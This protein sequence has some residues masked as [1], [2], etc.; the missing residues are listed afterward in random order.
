MQGG[1]NVKQ[2]D[3]DWVHGIMQEVDSK[4][5]Y[6]V[7]KETVSAFQRRGCTLSNQIKNQIP[8]NSD[9]KVYIMRL[10]QKEKNAKKTKKTKQVYPIIVNTNYQK[11]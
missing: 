1:E 11:Y 5:R 6:C 7:S 2:T 3:L 4:S 9:N 10:V 8:F